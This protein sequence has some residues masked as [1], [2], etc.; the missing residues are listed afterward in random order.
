MTATAMLLGAAAPA[1]PATWRLTPDGLG[2]L[3]IGMTRAHA[4]ATLGARITTRAPD[5]SASTACEEGEIDGYRGLYL[6]FEQGR[7]TR[8]DILADT[9][10]HDRPARFDVTGNRTSDGLR[11]GSTEQDVLRVYGRRLKIA[12]APYLDEPAHE[13]TMIDA[14]AG[15]GRGLVFETDDH[16]VVVDIRA[17]GKAIG[18]MEGCL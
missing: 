15:S 3:H 4:G 13:L 16:G 10:P 11:L 12:T 5:G 18:Y 17:G 1:P 14:A 7:L 9:G 8:I 6:L 2:P